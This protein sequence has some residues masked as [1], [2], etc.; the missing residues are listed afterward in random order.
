MDSELIFT[1]LKDAKGIK[2][3]L[4][5]HITI[6]MFKG[7]EREN[8]TYL[9][10]NIGANFSGDFYIGETDYLIMNEPASGDKFVGAKN[11]SPE[12]LIVTKKW[13][14]DTIIHWKIQDHK[15][16]YPKEISET[17]KTIIKDM[18]N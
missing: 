12:T 2:E 11:K 3:I 16:Y 9:I 6:S 15:K 7:L 18:Q 1:P 14:E 4:D 17:Y 5:K 10:R 8:L 13:L